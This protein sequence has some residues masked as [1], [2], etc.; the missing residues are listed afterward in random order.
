MMPALVMGIDPGINGAVAI[1]DPG[2]IPLVRDLPVTSSTDGKR[3]LDACTFA[4]WVSTFCLSAGPRRRL[5]VLEKVGAMTY[6]DRSG[7]K[8][9]QGAAASFNFGRTY[10]QIEGVLAAASRTD[11]INLVRVPPAVWKANLGL[12]HEKCTSLNMARNFW[13]SMVASFSKAKDHDRAEAALLAYYGATRL[14]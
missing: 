5:V 6:V 2:G 7:Q 4:G 14:T 13:P 9:G 1:Y 8:R 12:T 3:E 10:G 11:S